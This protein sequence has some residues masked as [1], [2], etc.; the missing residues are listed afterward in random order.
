M[1]A[2]SLSTA[3][4]SIASLSPASLLF[5]FFFM[6]PKPRLLRSMPLKNNDNKDNS[7]KLLIQSAERQSAERRLAQK[8][9]CTLI[10]AAPTIEQH[11][12]DT[13]A[14]NQMS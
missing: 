8:E 2:A 14:G 13:Y 5:F 11:K 4:P 12:L 9:L 10:L 3:S 1:S 7:L 6:L